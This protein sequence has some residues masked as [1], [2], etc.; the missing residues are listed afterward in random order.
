MSGGG[1]ITSSGLFTAPTIA[2]TVSI[3]VKDQSNV[4]NTAYAVITV[5][6]NSLALTATSSTLA[7]Y[8][9]DQLTATGGTA[10]YTYAIISQTGGVGTITSS[11]LYTAPSTFSVAEISVTDSS[12]TPQTAYATINVNTVGYQT[13]GT[14][15][16]YETNYSITFA[17]LASYDSNCTSA[18]PYSDNCNAAINRYC[19]QAN[20]AVSGFGPIAISGSNVKLTCVSSGGATLLNAAW[21]GLQAYN[22]SCYTGSSP[23]AVSVQCLAAINRYCSGL[24]FV[25]GFGPVEHTASVASVVCVTTKIAT[26]VNDSF[27]DLVSYNSGCTLNAASSA[28]CLSATSQYCIAN[29]YTSGFGVMEDS[30]STA[31]WFCLN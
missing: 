13:A 23:N 26:I 30:L 7:T 3:Q 29:G 2:A 11:G 21:S 9:T 31:S 24:G 28:S 12:T 16:G 17:K 25:S 5:A 18:T 22:S 20:S 1:S 10:P 15:T 19:Q 8:A 27:A 6:S 4:A 14:A